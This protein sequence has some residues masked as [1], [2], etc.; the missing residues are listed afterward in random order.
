MY[1]FHDFDENVV[2]AIRQHIESCIEADGLDDCFP[3]RSCLREDVFEVLNRYCIVIYFP[4]EDESNRG[5]HI[6]EYLSRDGS[7][8]DFVFINT[9]QTLEKQVFTAAHELGHIWQIDELILQKFSYLDRDFGEA[10]INRFAAELLMPEAPFRSAVIAD[11]RQF[12]KAKD[13]NMLKVG[14]RDVLKI[15]VKRMDQFRAPSGA[16]I[17]RLFELHIIPQD[18]MNTLLGNG[19]LPKE[20]V[21]DEIG[22]IIRE[23]DY[24]SLRNPTRRKFV[25]GL[26][27]LLNQAEAAHCVAESKINALRN[28]F[29]LPQTGAS[30]ELNLN[31]P[32]ETE[33]IVEN[34]ICT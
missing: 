17:R 7:D 33:G 4:I 10:I 20:I 13:S 28:K 15:V 12:N 24:S 3:I 8:K 16:V 18:A 5:F 14:M 11:A 31:V 30:S 19:P 2:T 21:D 25:H 1:D 32:I 23:N 22:R 9:S 27:E 34:G 26:A 6:R 29:D